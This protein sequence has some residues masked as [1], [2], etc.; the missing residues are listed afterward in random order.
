MLCLLLTM[1]FGN[2]CKKEKFASTYYPIPASAALDS[3]TV[4]NLGDTTVRLTAQSLGT[5]LS[6]RWSVAN[7][8]AGDAV[9]DSIFNPT[10]LFHGEYFSSYVILWEI[11]NGR[12]FRVQT[13]QVNFPVPKLLTDTFFQTTD[14]FVTLTAF[15]LSKTLT[16]T[17]S[18][19]SANTSSGK[20]DNISDPKTIFHG[21]KGEKYTLRWTVTNHRISIYKEVIVKLNYEPFVDIRDGEKYKIVRIGSQIWMAE[22][23]RYKPSNAVRHYN[24]NETF[25]TTFGYLY[26][27]EE[28]KVS[29]P[30]G[31][32][33]PTTSE[34]FQL[35]HYVQTQNGDGALLLKSTTGWK[36]NGTTS[37]NG[38]DA[39]DFNALPGGVCNTD[40]TSGVVTFALMTEEGNFWTT[41]LYETYPV[42]IRFL[43]SSDNI[44]NAWYSNKT[45]IFSRKSVRCI[46]D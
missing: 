45:N 29:A 39:Y 46:K 10:T 18:V 33:L 13:T 42:F 37:G 16:G 26:S 36:D 3:I 31:W 44:A 2:S 40:L 12:D 38:T 9:F 14:T 24:D 43:Y 23:L 27:Q 34:W 5:G 22:N 30:I 32:H 25:N 15:P 19:T 4:Q 7:Y 35:I 6:G 28:A 11:T 41:D 1:L 8:V 20:F 21:L 17:W